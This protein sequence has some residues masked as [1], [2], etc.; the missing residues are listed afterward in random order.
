MINNGRIQPS[1]FKRAYFKKYHANFALTISHC[2]IKLL[3]R[4]TNRVDKDNANNETARDNSIDKR[5]SDT[6]KDIKNEMDSF[7]ANIKSGE[8]PAGDPTRSDE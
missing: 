5:K 6:S 8:A 7:E 4:S 3:F 1:F 2:N